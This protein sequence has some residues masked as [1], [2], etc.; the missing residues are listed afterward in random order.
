[1]ILSGIDRKILN[2]IVSRRSE[3]TAK[4]APLL[5]DM[6]KEL[7]KAGGAKDRVK[8]FI[9][10]LLPVK[11]KGAKEEIP[12]E[13]LQQEVQELMK[14]LKT[15]KP[16]GET[17]LLSLIPKDVLMMAAGSLDKPQVLAALSRRVASGDLEPFTHSKEGRALAEQINN[18]QLQFPEVG[19]ETFLSNLKMAGPYVS[20]LNCKDIPSDAVRE[21]IELCVDPATEHMSLKELSLGN[22]MDLGEGDIIRILEKCPHLESLTIDSEHLSDRVLNLLP[23]FCPHLQHLDFYA[24]QTSFEGV[25]TTVEKLPQLKTINLGF[26]GRGPNAVKDKTWNNLVNMKK[27]LKVSADEAPPLRR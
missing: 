15:S 20:R 14:E 8:K 3:F 2:L 19:K 16:R 22:R 27:G 13:R 6:K 1:M 24:A 7:L 17:S 11:S 26:W 9:T 25:K 12:I 5:K 23:I 4:D 21:V 18:D 10:D